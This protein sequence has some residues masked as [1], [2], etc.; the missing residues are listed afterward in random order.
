M[1]EH[2]ELILKVAFIPSRMQII[3]QSLSPEETQQD[4]QVHQP[5]A[6]ITIDT[7]WVEAI[8]CCRLLSVLYPTYFKGSEHLNYVT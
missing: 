5:S 8:I 2:S 4:S 7:F 3:I 6:S 1:T